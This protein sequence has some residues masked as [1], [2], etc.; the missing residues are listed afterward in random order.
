MTKEENSWIDIIVR[1]LKTAEKVG[2]DNVIIEPNVIR[3]IND[4][5]TVVLFQ[6]ENVPQL[7][8]GSIGINRI[9][10]FM[11]RYNIIVS[12]ENPHFEA[13]VNEEKGFVRSIDMSSDDIVSSD[14]IDIT[15]RCANP[16][17]IQA[18]K[19][20]NDVPVYQFIIPGRTSSIMK[21]AQ[22]AMG[23]E[24]VEI[25]S[26]GDSVSYKIVDINNDN[27]NHIFPGKVVNIDDEEE[28]STSFSY[29]Y[30]VKN[31][32]SVI[33]SDIDTMFEIGEKGII[34]TVVNGLNVLILP[35]V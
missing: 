15:Y 19:K 17:T 4:A 11:Q 13:D 21:Q 20:I 10:T 2:I 28:T 29:K 23:S 12:R 14:D 22:A 8:V 16:D 26:D 24:T 27:F 34:T 3:A 25:T 7:S 18:P 32:L 33:D 9:G 35:Q 31:I 6:N 5:K 30:P 1:V